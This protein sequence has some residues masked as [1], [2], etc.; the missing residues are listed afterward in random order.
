M[1]G[2]SIDA[3]ELL[4]R[5]NFNFFPLIIYF[6]PVLQKKPKIENKNGLCY[7]QAKEEIGSW[8]NSSFSIHWWIKNQIILTNG[9]AM[10]NIKCKNLRTCP[11]E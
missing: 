10:N 9:T 8:L 1:E 5:N 6:C 3:G 11:A 2:L 4:E 7:W